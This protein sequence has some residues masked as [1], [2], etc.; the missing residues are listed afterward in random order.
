MLY[1]YAYV[2]FVNRL[3]ERYAQKGEKGVKKRQPP[4]FLDPLPYVYVLGVVVFAFLSSCCVLQ[5]D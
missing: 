2:Y 4:S 1:V 3:I 5:P